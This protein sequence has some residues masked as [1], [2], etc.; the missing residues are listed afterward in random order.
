MTNLQKISTGFFVASLLITQFS[1][2]AS[3]T[4]FAGPYDIQATKDQIE[5]MAKDSPIQTPGDVTE[6]IKGIVRWTYYIF[7]VLAVYFILIAAFGYLTA[8]G[9]PEKIKSANS[10]LLWA[11]VA[12]AVALISV[13]AAQIITSFI[14]PPGR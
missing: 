3:N 13:G 11:F 1:F 2:L 8:G 7:F 9:N 14:T 4:V 5:K 6:V 12:I 10:S